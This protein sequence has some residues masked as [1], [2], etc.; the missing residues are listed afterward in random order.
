MKMHSATDTALA[1]YDDA[2]GRRAKNPLLRLLR[3]AGALS[4][5]LAGVAF[6]V[7]VSF[8]VAFRWEV[9]YGVGV[10]SSVTIPL[11]MLFWGEEVA[12]TGGSLSVAVK[13][14]AASILTWVVEVIMSVCIV[15]AAATIFGTHL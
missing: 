12:W 5:L 14:M 8:E 2:P 4:T 7:L 3:A 15:V 9:Y 1:D 6:G 10:V 11:I 13:V